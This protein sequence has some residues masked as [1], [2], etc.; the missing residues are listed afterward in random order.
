MMKI[1]NFSLGEI[2]KGKIR[3]LQT[4]LNLPCLP[5]LRKSRTN[6]MTKRIVGCNNERINRRNPKGVQY[7]G[8]RKRR[9]RNPMGVQDCGRCTHR[10]S[11][12]NNPK[13]GNVSC[14]F[15]PISTIIT[16]QVG[17]LRLGRRLV[18]Q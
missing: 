17:P 7:C 9:R 11:H 8:R 2:L 14:C 5:H 6:T 10:H 12:W 3:I 4:H 15:G 16:I 13:V 18:K 1:H